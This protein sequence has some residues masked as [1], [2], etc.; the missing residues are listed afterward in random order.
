MSG[1]QNQLT[2]RF[3][4]ENIPWSG[5]PGAFA[6]FGTAWL[7]KRGPM[8]GRIVV[9]TINAVGIFDVDVA[10]A[11]LLGPDVY[12]LFGPTTVKQDGYMRYNEIP[13]DAMRT[14]L[15]EQ[16]G[17]SR[18]KEHADVP[19]GPGQQVIATMVIPLAKP[20]L[21]EPGDYS[22][23]AEEL[24][25]VRIKC[26]SDGD[27]ALG[28]SAVTINSGDYYL[29]FECHEEL[30]VVVHAIDEVKIQD[31]SSPTSQ[32]ER[33]NVEGRL[34]E[35]IL[36]VRGASGGASLANM[37]SAWIHQPQW[38]A[39]ELRVNP[40]LKEFFAR[41][42]GEASSSSFANG[43]PLYSSPYTDAVTRAV[44]VLLA[45]GTK[46]FDSPE[47]ESAIV[48][49]EHTLGATIRMIA[50]VAKKREDATV[51]RI[52]RA[53]KLKGLYRVKTA[54]NQQRAPQAWPASVIP[55]LPIKFVE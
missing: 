49:C 23:A 42:R 1:N 33:L 35:L 26:A 41:S 12:R 37:T 43:D 38:L 4:S 20:A 24:Q 45:T 48:K 17:A 44:A 8:G 54:S 9:D 6:Q 47:I 52:R 10:G 18:V 34:Q 19:I 13:G 36:M 51:E 5:A 11:A 2:L 31:F 32:E 25:F 40:D 7:P 55:Y 3:Q 50:R 39:P 30:D 46:A 14:F 27:L 21:H 22:L 53:K 28:A 16:F 29:V 15:F